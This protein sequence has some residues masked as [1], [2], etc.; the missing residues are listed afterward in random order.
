V[1]VLP[2]QQ[3]PAVEE[4]VPA[5]PHVTQRELLH[6]VLASLQ[7]L[8]AQQGPLAAPQIVQ[9]LLALSQTVPGS[10]HATVVDV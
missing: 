3:G 4:V 5:V 6:T 9:M 7:V 8:L 1:H 2:A 10:L